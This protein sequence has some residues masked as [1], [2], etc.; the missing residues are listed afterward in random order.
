LFRTTT[1]SG[2]TL[3]G[4]GNL[5][6]WPDAPSSYAVAGAVGQFTVHQDQMTPVLVAQLS[7]VAPPH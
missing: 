7:E 2:G 5:S 4:F 3:Y 1:T 6:G